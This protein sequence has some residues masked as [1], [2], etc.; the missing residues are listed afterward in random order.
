MASIDS[1]NHI[2]HDTHYTVVVQMVTYLTGILESH[3]RRDQ[4][5]QERLSRFIEKCYAVHKRLED[6]QEP[7]KSKLGIPELSKTLYQGVT[8]EL[9]SWLD[10][11]KSRR[12]EVY[13]L[14]A[15]PPG[16]VDE[17]K[18]VR[19]VV[20]E[21]VVH[22]FFEDKA[23]VIIMVDGDQE[24]RLMSREQLSRA[25]VIREGQPFNIEVAERSTPEGI[26]ETIRRIKRT[27]DPS[28]WTMR[29]VR[30]E[31]NIQKFKAPRED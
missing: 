1:L 8:S 22:E 26:L 20:L 3:V 9:Q 23:L 15:V 10:E 7:E 5:E 17:K 13:L 2:V 6:I 12:S 18:D 24:K 19:E 31:L 25:G 14:G 16:E 29:R 21:C 30:P 28:K 4:A 11:S 27:G